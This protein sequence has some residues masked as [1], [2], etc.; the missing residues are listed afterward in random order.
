MGPSGVTATVCSKCA[1]RLPSRV[2]AVQ[3]SASTFTAGFPIVTIM[4]MRD[5][6]DGNLRPRHPWWSLLRTGAAVLSTTLVFYAFSVLPLAQTYAIVFA[7]PLLITVL[8]IPILGERVGW[9]RSA[10]VLVGLVGV[11]VVLR[12]G[13]TTL[14]AGHAAALGAAVCSAVAAVVVRK[15]G[16]EERSAVLLLLGMVLATPAADATD[17]QTRTFTWSPERLL[18]VELTV[19]DVRILGSDRDDLELAVQRTAPSTEALADIP[20][21][22]EETPSA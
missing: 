9:H 4:L 5:A 6:T 10:A 1:A 17:R 13:A 18:V 8:A 22:V 20:L 16:N 12:P 11:I 3:P 21:A 2:T 7:A 14:T 15:I 19:G